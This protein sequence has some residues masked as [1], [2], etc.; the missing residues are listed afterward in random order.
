MGAGWSFFEDALLSF[1]ERYFSNMNTFRTGTSSIYG[2]VIMSRGSGGCSEFKS[3][4]P[5]LG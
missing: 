3:S 2:F 1:L 4:V 5:I